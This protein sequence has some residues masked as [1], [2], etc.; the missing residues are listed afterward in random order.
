MQTPEWFG[1][2][3]WTH[4]GYNLIRTLMAQAATTS[5]I[6]P[7]TIS[8]KAPWQTLEAFQPMIEQQAV[9]DAVCALRLYHNLLGAMRVI[10]WKTD[11]IALNRGPRKNAAI[12]MPG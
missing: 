6:L 10:A 11:Q 3:I 9:H 7:R 2:E 1:K 12:I 8:F 4:V 5:R